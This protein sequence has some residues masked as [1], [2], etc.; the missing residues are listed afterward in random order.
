MEKRLI[1]NLDSE[2]LDYTA[3]CFGF[4]N[5]QTN[6]SELV[7]KALLYFLK[8]QFMINKYSISDIDKNV[9]E[10]L[11]EPDVD[12]EKIEKDY[13]FDLSAVEGKWPGDEP[14]GLL[15]EMLKK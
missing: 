1:I 15:L 14:I 6:Y 7:E 2:L 5:T 10:L 4:K 11:T 13:H 8:P 12:I 3:Q 9:Q